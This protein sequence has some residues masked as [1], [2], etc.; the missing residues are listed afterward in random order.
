MRLWNI[1][2]IV[3]RGKFIALDAYI[4]K[5]E[6]LKISPLSFH[7]WKLEKEQLEAKDDRRKE[8]KGG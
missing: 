6:K 8:I 3:L 7:F 2:K 5:E 4:R 1:A